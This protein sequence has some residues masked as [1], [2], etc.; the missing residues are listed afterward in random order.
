LFELHNKSGQI[1]ELGNTSD[2]RILAVGKTTA[3]AWAVNKMYD[4]VGNYLTV[5][6]INDTTNGQF[7]PSRVDYTGHSGTPLLSTFNS[8]RFSYTTRADVTPLYHGGS[9]MQT[10]VLLS[11][12][13]TYAGASVVYDYKLAYQAGTSTTVSRLTSITLCDASTNCVAPTTFTWQGTLDVLTPTASPITLAGTFNGFVPTLAPGDFNGDGLTDVVVEI[14]SGGTC[15]SG[16]SIYLG[17]LASSFVSGNYIVGG[18]PYCPSA[19]IDPHWIAPIDIEGD[20]YTDLI[21]TDDTVT[22]GISIYSSKLFHNNNAGGGTSAVLSPLAY[23]TG[24]FDGNGRSDY[25]NYDGSST[26][27]LMLGSGTGTFSSVVYSSGVFTAPATP[28]P[29]GDFDGD[30]CSDFVSAGVRLTCAPAVATIA[31]P[32]SPYSGYKFVLGDFNGDGLTDLL[33]FTNGAAGALFLSTGTGFVQQSFSVPTDWGKYAIYTADFNGDGKTDLLLVAPGG[34]GMYAAPTTHKIFLS[35]G[36][37]FVQ[38]ATIANSAPGSVAATVA[39][40]NND[41]AADI[42]LQLSGATD[43]EVTLAYTPNLLTKIS[44]G[45]G[46]TTAIAYDRLNKGG[47]FYTKGSGATYPTQ[48]SVDARYV[49]SRVDASNGLGVCT[50]PSPT[51]CYTSTYSYS[52]AKT[53]LKGRGFLGFST[54]KITDAQT[55]IVRTTNYRTDFP[56]AG[57]IASESSAT[58]ITRG[59]CLAAVTLRSVSNTYSSTLSTGVYFVSLQSAVAAGHDCDGTT[60]PTTTANMTYDTYGNTLTVGI[61]VSDGSSKTTTNTYYNDSVN[62]IVGRLTSTTVNRVVGSSN[63]TRTSTFNY[64]SVT[65]LLTREAVEPSSNF[66][67]QTDYTYDAFGHRTTTTVSGAG[68]GPISGIAT[69]SSSVGYDSAGTFQTST[70]NALSQS[71]SSIYNS[72]FGELTSH[73]DLNGLSTTAGY[74]TLGRLTLETAPVGTKIVESYAYC[75]GINGGS[76]TCPTNGTYLEQAKPVASD[77]VTQI[78]PISTTY[79]DALARV[80]AKDTQGFDASNIRGATQYDANGRVSQTSRPYFTT[81]GTP[82]WT[83]FTYDDL[84]RVTQATLPDSSHNN[85]AYHG[86]ST[87]VTNA[88]NQVTTRVKNAQDLVASV[89][90]PA[91]KVTSY[92]YDSFGEVVSVTDSAGNVATNVHDLRG[93]KTAST[94]PDLGSWSYAYDSLGELVTQ[95]DAKSQVTTLAYDVVGH[96]LTRTEVGLY[97]VWTFG[98]SSTDHNVGQLI[99]TKSCASVGC[100]TVITDRTFGYDSLSRTAAAALTTGGATFTT[101]TTYDAYSRISTVTR[102]SGLTLQKVYTALG[103]LCRITDNAGSPT[104]TS[105]GGANVIWTANTADAELHTLQTT[106]GNG[107]VTSDSYDANTGR[108]TNVRA[109]PSDTVASFDYTWD[110]IGNLTY[111]SDNFQGLFERFC[112]DN[113]NRLTNSSSGN[114]AVTTCTSSGSGITVKTLSYDELGDISNKSDVGTY[115]YPASGATSVRPHAVASIAGTVNGVTNPTYAYDNNGNMTSGAGRTVSYTAFNMADTITQGTNSVAFSYDENHTRVTQTSTSG[116]S[117]TVTTYINDPTSETVVEQSITAGTITW[118]DYVEVSGNIAAERFCTGAAPCSSGAAWE[119]FVSDQLGS[120]SVLTDAGGTVTERLSYDAWGRRRNADGT[121]NSACAVTS[122]TTRGFTGHEMLDSVCEINANARI[123]DPTIGRFMSA[124]TLVADSFNSQSLNRY[125]YVLNGPLSSKDPSGH[126]IEQVIVNGDK[127]TPEELAAISLADIL[128]A[129]LVTGNVTIHWSTSGYGGGLK[130]AITKSQMVTG[131]R[132]AIQQTSSFDFNSSGSISSVD[133]NSDGTNTAAC[134][135]AKGSVPAGLG[136]TDEE[137]QLAAKGDVEGFYKARL[138]QGDPV[139]IIGLES[140]HPSGGLLDYLFGGASANNRLEAFARVYT[141][142]SIDLQAVRIDLMNAEIRAV[143]AD[144]EGVIGLLSPG[145]VYDYHM[146]V[147]QKYHLPPEAFGGTPFTG[148]RWEVY[149]WTPIWGRGLDW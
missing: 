34:T 29:V 118:H 16:G 41:G 83:T 146:A 51:N 80:I 15:P 148:E 91:N 117:S 88:L 71:D 26:L 52:G 82:K 24:D 134:D 6:Y 4:L 74:D 131:S 137:R 73:T 112:Y 64:D 54:I 143:D 103:Y 128:I 138:A 28:L 101:T 17:T 111:R 43:S 126:V 135:N 94:D 45:V 72:T 36:V 140:L 55:G 39:D 77:G 62:W 69:R 46:A 63:I 90:D 50:P 142:H 1:E 31:T 102:P 108:V 147:F 125:S 9:I 12:I 11:D 22:H 13:K 19:H 20:G 8:V 133:V 49:V 107:I 75:A 38:K 99:E 93:N 10:T 53:D 120:A 57:S 141:G 5:T 48:D 97:S 32:G 27:K 130:V 106:A 114:S 61:S 115:S 109:G 44:N 121:D 123:Y 42:W 30:S 79:F 47:S 7:Y 136:I 85:Y 100:A 129:R 124:D 23:G 18:A 139:A 145:Q 2:S 66:A 78:G 70:T 14:A 149:V 59:G 104:C 127:L 25:L 35:T 98:S 122:A 95:T 65:G 40:W 105:A 144:K 58:T 96:V 87:S 60:L 21:F 3:R 56:Y 116:G 119:Y 37:G 86:L 110:S 67:L 89:T 33:Y 113:L 132:I 81:G 76:A 92:T 68:G 84:G